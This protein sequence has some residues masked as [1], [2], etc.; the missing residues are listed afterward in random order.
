ML[1]VYV[2]GHGYGHATRTAEVLRV[3]REKVPA[4][5]IVV[6]TTAPAFL[7][8]R[9]IAAPL[10]VRSV[11]ADVGLAQKDALTID[12]E[13]TVAAWRAFMAGWERRVEAEARWL[14]ESGA[15]LVLGDVPPLAFAAAARA[16]LAATALTNFSWDWIYA[17]LAP[18]N[19]AFG[20]A[21]V[22][23][24]EAYRRCTLLLRLPF[25]GDLSAFPRIEDLPLVARRPRVGKGEA[26]R[27]L[28]LGERPVV[29]LSFGGVGVRGLPLNNPKI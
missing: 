8:E 16:G 6:A 13:G 7:F 20:E 5:P 29:L 23:A 10:A 12:E 27:R 26:R 9:T 28:G 15:R 17:H 18:R 21:A 24:R 4:L 25:A 3:L 1:A 22:W 14:R 11:P 19:A 2:S